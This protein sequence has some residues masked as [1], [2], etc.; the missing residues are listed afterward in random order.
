MRCLRTAVC[1][2]SLVLSIFVVEASPS[3]DIT[4]LP[5]YIT[6]FGDNSGGTIG[7]EPYST[8]NSS[9]SYTAIGYNDFSGSQVWTRWY[10]P[11]AGIVENCPST[12]YLDPTIT[13][14]PADSAAAFRS[15]VD[16]KMSQG[17]RMSSSN[18]TK[19]LANDSQN[20]TWIRCVIVGTPSKMMR[21][22]WQPGDQSHTGKPPDPVKPICTLGSDVV[23]D[24][25][26]NSLNVAGMQQQKTVPIVCSA[27][28]LSAD[29][30]LRLTSSSA[31]NG[32]I[33][34]GNNVGVSFMLGST[35]LPVNGNGITLSL[36]SSSSPILTATL[37]GTAISVGKTDASGILIL[38]AL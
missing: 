1:T 8:G 10:Y 14:I 19:Y 6:M 35:A 3:Y 5:D 26:S 9:F 13:Y 2:G 36:T 30:R 27:G 21:L 17:V 29:Y 38:E 4:T 16:Q 18:P 25:K 33:L 32:N 34:F 24:F 12:V 11:G 23:F 28:G 15:W 22:A 31:S 20:T 7:T 37:T